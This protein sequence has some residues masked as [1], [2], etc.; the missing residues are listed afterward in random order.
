MKSRASLKGH[1]IHP[2]LIPFPFAFL[3]GGW[4]FGVAGALLRNRD[5]TT[6]SRHLVPTGIAAGLLAAVPGAID[7]FGSVPPASS[8]SKRATQH[9]LVNVTALLLFAAGWMTGRRSRRSTLSLTLQGMGTAAI[10]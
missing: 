4:G 7:Y 3:T 1:P 9:A 2:M 10:S 8:A 5:L 6:V